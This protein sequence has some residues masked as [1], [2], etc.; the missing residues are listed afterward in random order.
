MVKNILE[1]YVRRKSIA[2]SKDG[3]RCAC[4]SVVVFSEYGT[5]ETRVLQ[6]SSSR[7]KP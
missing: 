6:R 1:S 5:R 2:M 7:A 3:K 4:K